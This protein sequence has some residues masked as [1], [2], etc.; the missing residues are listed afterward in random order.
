MMW[1][2]TFLFDLPPQHT[3]IQNLRY[4]FLFPFSLLPRVMR[5]FFV[6]ACTHLRQPQLETYRERPHSIHHKE[7]PQRF[8]GGHRG[9]GGRCSAAQPPGALEA[10]VSSKRRARAPPQRG[11]RGAGRRATAVAS[12]SSP[13]SFLPNRPGRGSQFALLGVVVVVVVRRRRRR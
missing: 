1:T 3:G 7:R 2:W 4:C 5:S 10:N 12:G 8:D 9:G 11:G 6:C 13:S